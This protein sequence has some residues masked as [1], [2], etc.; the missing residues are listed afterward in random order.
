MKKRALIIISFVLAL[1]A[2]ASLYSFGYLGKKPFKHL[3]TDSIRN[4]D[5][6][7]IPPQKTVAINDKET[8]AELAEILS[9]VTIYRQDDSGRDYVGQLVQYTI[10][11]ATGDTHE[12]GAYGRF[13]YIDNVCY[14]TKYKPSEELNALGN[15]II[16]SH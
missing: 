5:V 14:I 2:F 16:K 15:K 9:R 13:I 8:L 7:V 3:N 6:F 1:A 11:L 12:I 4:A 10:T